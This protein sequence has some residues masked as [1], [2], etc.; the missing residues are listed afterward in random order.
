MGIGKLSE[1]RTA[2]DHISRGPSTGRE[3]PCD[4]PEEGQQENTGAAASSV[5]GCWWQVW[6]LLPSCRCLEGGCS[7]VERIIEMNEACNYKLVVV[8]VDRWHASPLL[9]TA[10]ESTIRQQGC[11]WYCLLVNVLEVLAGR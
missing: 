9:P 7:K 11:A 2:D 8:S 3:G 5:G 6:V 1:Y 10:A 4:S